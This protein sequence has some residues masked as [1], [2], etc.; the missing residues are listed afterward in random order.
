[1]RTSKPIVKYLAALILTVVIITGVSKTMFGLEAIGSLLQRLTS[2]GAPKPAS[3]YNIPS[4]SFNSI[5]TVQISQ[6]NMNPYQ[7]ANQGQ[8]QGASTYKAPASSGGAYGPYGPQLP[9]SSGG[10][11]NYAAPSTGGQAP[12][13]GGDNGGGD[14]RLGILQGLYNNNRSYLE[15][16]APQYDNTYNTAK[17]D[18]QTSIDSASNAAESQKGDVN[19]QFG[20]ILKNQL[21][22]YQD[23]NRQRQGT[24]SSLGTL[25]S[26]AY[27]EQQFRADQN[28]GDQRSQTELQK[29]KTISGIDSQ[30][31]AYKQNATGYLSNLATQYQQGKNALTQALS[32][33]NLQ[34]AGALQDAI[35]QISQRAQEVQSNM[36]NWATQA[37]LLKSQGVD[38]TGALR[39]ING[40]QYAS[41]VANQLASAKQ[42]GNSLIPQLIGQPQGQGYV[43][44][45]NQKDKNN[46]L[47]QLGLA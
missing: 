3:T 15:G 41:N 12:G 27:G 42:F 30:L 39:G 10:G 13:G 1:M 31:N 17:N 43:G 7:S 38:V 47:A 6:P 44:N 20:D 35:D 33:N 22:T 28:L 19:S 9:A 4:G 46:L 16:L 37:A 36:Q 23:L 29:T 14:N 26:S 32:Q 5:P 45:S 18:L 2:G 25:D 11:N 24:F 34:E 8:V 21:Q 40:D